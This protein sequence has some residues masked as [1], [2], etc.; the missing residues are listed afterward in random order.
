M[1]DLTDAQIDAALTLGNAARL[2]EP[3]AA[4][5]RHDRALGRVV[6]ELTNGCTFAFPPRL[7][8]GLENASAEQLAEVEILGAGSG[9][10]WES[11]DVDLSVPGLLAGLLGTKAHMARHAGQAR[12]PA[13]T[14]AARRNGSKGGRPR[15]STVGAG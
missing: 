3:R 4:T 13:K 10:H 8:Q 15:K 5:A 12:S 2:A 14:A 11:L 1:A 9:L 7:A 6:I